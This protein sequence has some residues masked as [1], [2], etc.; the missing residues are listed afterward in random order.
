[1]KYEFVLEQKTTLPIFRNEIGSIEQKVGM[2]ICFD[3]GNNITTF[4]NMTPD[5][6]QMLFP[7]I[8]NADE[9]VDVRSADG[10]RITSCLY[11]IP[12]FMLIDKDNRILHINNM[13][14]RLDDS[15]IK[16]I[17]ILLAGDVFYNSSAT[18]TPK[19]TEDG[20]GYYRA[21]KVNTLHEG[22]NTLVMQRIENDAGKFYVCGLNMFI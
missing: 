4:Y 9:E 12:D 17:D 2:N 8:Q 15:K 7:D 18:V 13:F 21:L 16:M 22:K 3:T 11:I 1:M 10:N 19:R 14:C 5:F 6:L 20:K